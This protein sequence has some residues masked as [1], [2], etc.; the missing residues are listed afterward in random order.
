MGMHNKETYTRVYTR[1]C[2]RNNKRV[3][4]T[5][6]RMIRVC[7]VRIY[8]SCTVQYFQ[9]RCSNTESFL[10]CCAVNSSQLDKILNFVQYEREQTC[11]RSCIVNSWQLEGIILDIARWWLSQTSQ[12][13]LQK[14]HT[15]SPPTVKLYV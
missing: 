15:K 7:V 9:L 4:A 6:A 10:K 13:I 14:C 8:L 3:Y 5:Y 11:A 2:A 12:W 1:I